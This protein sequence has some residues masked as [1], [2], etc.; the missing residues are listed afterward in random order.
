VSSYPGAML[1]PSEEITEST[2]KTD[3]RIVNLKQPKGEIFYTKNRFIEQN[4]CVIP[5]L[6]EVK[7]E[8]IVLSAANPVTIEVEK[9]RDDKS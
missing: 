6:A 3:S 8:D 4:L 1:T 9:L 7:E 2:D 5:K